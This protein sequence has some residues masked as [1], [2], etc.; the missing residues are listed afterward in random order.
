MTLKELCPKCDCTTCKH[1]SKTCHECRTCG[2]ADTVGCASYEREEEAQLD[3][4][5]SDKD[6]AEAKAKGLDLDNWDDYVEFYGLGE[7]I[8]YDDL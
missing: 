1:R 2:N 4:P 7:E 3:R 5:Y 6:Y 8:N